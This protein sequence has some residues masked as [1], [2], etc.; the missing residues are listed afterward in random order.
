MTSDRPEAPNCFERRHAI[1]PY[2]EDLQLPSP[3]DS[4]VIV[5]MHGITVTAVEVFFTVFIYYRLIY[6]LLLCCFIILCSYVVF[7]ARNRT[8]YSKYPVYSPEIQD[9]LVILAKTLSAV[10]R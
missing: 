9:Y 7:Q 10:L 6:L 1:M 2:K 4:I 8:G 3:D 5:A